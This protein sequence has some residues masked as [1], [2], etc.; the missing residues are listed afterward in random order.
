MSDK[1]TNQA[2]KD[3][4]DWLAYCLSI[5][6]PKEA[7]DSLEKLWWKHHDNNGKLK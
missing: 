2:I 3:C 4:A 6:F 7:L 1:P 5:G